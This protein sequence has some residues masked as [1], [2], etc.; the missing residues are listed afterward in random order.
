MAMCT[1]WRNSTVH[2][3]RSSTITARDQCGACPY[4]FACSCSMDE[5]SGVSC[6]H[7]HAA[8]LYAAAGY[9]SRQYALPSVVSRK[10]ED[11]PYSSDGDE[12]VIEVVVEDHVENEKECTQMGLEEAKSRLE[13]FRKMID[14]LARNVEESENNV[15]L[16]RHPE[17]A[18]LRKAEQAK[19]KPVLDIPDCAQDERNAC[20]CPTCEDGMHQQ[21]SPSR[22][23]RPGK[24]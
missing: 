7:V 5:K 2:A 21:P 8:L 9:R 15:R 20:A 16:A 14:D 4:D 13:E 1:A 19:R 24:E 10:A 3:T 17:H 18:H 11:G 22:W 6:V 23:Y 12:E